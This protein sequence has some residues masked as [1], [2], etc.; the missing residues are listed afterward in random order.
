MASIMASLLLQADSLLEVRV[1]L[2]FGEGSKP[3]NIPLMSDQLGV[4]FSM[5]F[6]VDGMPLETAVSI[7]LIGIKEPMA[8]Y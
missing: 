5:C 1:A 3:W 7:P 4:K 6:A 8:R 2:I